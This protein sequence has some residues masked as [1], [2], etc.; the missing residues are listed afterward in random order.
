MGYDDLALVVS[1]AGRIRQLEQLQVVCAG[2]AVRGLDWDHH[3][4]Q[5]QTAM[6]HYPGG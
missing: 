4:H 1:L 2:V 5:S 3:R 6:Q